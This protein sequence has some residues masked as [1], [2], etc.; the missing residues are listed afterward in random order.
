M[1]S[2]ASIDHVM[3]LKGPIH[4]SDVTGPRSGIQALCSTNVRVYCYIHVNVLSLTWRTL[5]M[6]CNIDTDQ[7][8][9]PHSLIC[10]T[11]LF[12]NMLS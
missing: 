12:A 10:K 2:V 1:P 6:L 9:R 11:T 8:M 3:S 4:C 5:T 7:P